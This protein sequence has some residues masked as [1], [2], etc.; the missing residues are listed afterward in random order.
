MP[1]SGTSG[2]LSALFGDQGGYFAVL[3]LLAL[4]GFFLP[5]Y[6]L[7][8][9]NQ[10]LFLAVNVV[11][12]NFALG[13]GG[14]VSLAQSAF[15]GFGAY[16]S[17][18][19]LAVWPQA[20]IATVPLVV[21]AAWALGAG[22]SRPIEKLGE[23]FLAMATLGVALIFSNLLHSLDGLTGGASGMMVDAPLR[24]PAFLGGAALKGDLAYFLAYL[25]LLALAGLLFVRLKTGRLG[26]ALLACKDDPAA[27]SACGVDRASVRALAFGLAAA[28]AAA[29]GALYSHYAGFI[30]PKQFDLELASKTLLFLV[31]GGPGRL[32]RPL[33]AV[34]VLET[35]LAKAHFLGEARTL[36]HGLAL[37]GAL[38][39]GI[40]ADAGGRASAGSSLS[41]LRSLARRFK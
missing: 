7:L 35:L 30:S 24:L 12:L 38:L 29:S 36:F 17:A 9:V 5:S 18:L 16:A 1:E 19:A 13:L 26:R 33:I 31:I 41:A 32:A 28:L 34:L 14:Q 21:L 11:G 2:R 8:S 23:G 40:H 4:L 3:G 6:E 22:L 39:A 37:A 15:C 25:L 20:G 27:A 10:H